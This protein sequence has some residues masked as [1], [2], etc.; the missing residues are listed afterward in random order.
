MIFNVSIIFYCYRNRIGHIIRRKYIIDIAGKKDGV[1]KTSIAIYPYIVFYSWKIRDSPQWHCHV[2]I[3]IFRDVEPAHDAFFIFSSSVDVFWPLRPILYVTS[4][5]FLTFFKP[6]RFIM[7]TNVSPYVNNV[8]IG[9]YVFDQIS[10]SDGP[11]A[12]GNVLSADRIREM[13]ADS[14][15]IFGAGENDFW[16]TGVT[17]WSFIGQVLQDGKQS[18]CNAAVTNVTRY[19]LEHGM[20]PPSPD[21]GEYCRARHKLNIKVLRQIVCDIADKMSQ[22]N[23][24]RWLWHGKD[25]KLVDGFTFTMPDTPENQHEFP[26]SKSQKPGIGF[27]IARACAV[28]SLAN[29]CIH[30]VAIGP[31]A[32]KDTGETALLRRVLNCFKPGDVMLADR[33]FCSFFMLAILKSRGIDV[34]MRLHQIRKIDQSKVKWL[35]KNDYID[36]WK[37]PQ[38]AKWM[39]HQLYDSLPEQMQIRVVTFKAKSQDKTEQLNIVTSLL[40]HEKYPA[41][42]IGKLYGYRW[43]VELDLFSI[44]QSLNLDHLRCKSPDM[45]VR[46]FWVTLLAY[47]MVRLVCAQAAF[48]HDKSARNM[49]FT[50]ACNTLISQW[51]MP[52]DE[53]IRQKLNEH[54]LLQIAGNEVGRRPGRIEPRVVKRRPKEY[55]LMTKPRQQYKQ[56]KT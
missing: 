5:A 51:L 20:N 34:C 21:S 26:Q 30:N 15:A 23:P 19:M 49:S 37:K 42:E 35:G 47:N 12:F 22:L 32:G 41:G 8:N 24:D 55:S 33:Y 39:S 43:H 13:F 17:L 40:D 50:T 48:A 16:N 56:E 27:P 6:K 9:F 14:D 3:V 28:V 52:P 2:F 10:Y 36:T 29:A 11:L 4:P 45:I 53:S 31:Y 44:K 46:E 18:S 54:Y 25:V 1:K 38:K 7:I